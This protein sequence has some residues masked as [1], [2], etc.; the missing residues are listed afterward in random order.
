MSSSRPGPVREPLVPSEALAQVVVVGRSNAKKPSP[1][2]DR[3]IAD[4]QE[5]GVAVTLFETF[6]RRTS[7]FLDEALQGLNAPV[8]ARLIGQRTWAGIAT[9]RG[10]KF[11]ILLAYPSRWRYVAHVLTGRREDVAA[12]LRAF[13]RTRPDRPLSLI[14]H[15]AGC[16]AA[17]RVADEPA[18]RGLIGFGYPFRH[19]ERAE[20]PYRTAPLAGLRKPLL[21]LQGVRDPYG[22]TIDAGRYP[23]SPQVKLVSIDADHDYGEVPEDEYRRVRAL[24]GDV[25]GL[26]DMPRA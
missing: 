9:R 23:L 7:R 11:L 13:I 5:S 3:L 1:L 8:A 16:I 4:L 26:R 22:S 21:I 25:L 2:L 6:S 20:E 14:A 19:P 10:V 17:C 12:E 15:S 24:V 18:I